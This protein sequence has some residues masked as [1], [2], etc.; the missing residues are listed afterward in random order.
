MKSEGWWVKG[1]GKDEGV[2]EGKGDGNLPFLSLFFGHPI[3]KL[4]NNGV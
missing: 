1:E 3:V 4:P 2:G